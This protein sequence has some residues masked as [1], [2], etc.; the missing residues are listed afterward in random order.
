MRAPQNYAIIEH[1]RKL[2]CGAGGRIVFRDRGGKAADDPHAG[3]GTQGKKNDRETGL[4]IELLRDLDENKS[5][6]KQVD[7][8]P[9]QGLQI[10]T[11]LAI[12]PPAG[13][14]Q[15]HNRKAHIPKEQEP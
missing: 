11:K 13:A 6:N 5:R 14:K 3:N 2:Q 4:Q 12:H 9:H 8:Q 7:V 10:K 1:G 15:Q